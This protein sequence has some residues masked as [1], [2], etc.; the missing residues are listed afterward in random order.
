MGRGLLEHVQGAPAMARACARAHRVVRDLGAD[1]VVSTGGYASVPAVVAAGLARVPLALVEPNAIPGRANRVAARFARRIFVHFEAAAAAFG[2]ASGRVRNSGIP[3]RRALVACFANGHQRRLP[4]APLRLLVFGGSQGARQL[5]EAMMLAAGR[6]DPQAL[7]I[8]HQAGA[9][10]CQRVAAAYGETGLHA[11]VVAFEP[12][13]SR[14]YRWADVALC[15]AGALT[16]AELAMASLPSLLVPY[17]FAADDHQS[18]NAR[19]LAEAGAARV[20]DPRLPLAELAARVVETL[21][22]WCHAPGEL[23][24]MSGEASKLARPDAAER[25]VEECVAMLEGR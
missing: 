15:R 6:L 3:L 13:M 20:L 5:N 10:D 24:R 23:Q 11:E 9:E 8:F 25:I 4:A 17:P 22:G 21:G 1:L 7:Q 18:A 2:A 16:V 12:D 19:A 14:R